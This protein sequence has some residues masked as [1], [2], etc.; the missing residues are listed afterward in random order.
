[1]IKNT[2]TNFS[3]RNLAAKLESEGEEV[4]EKVQ[5]AITRAKE[6]DDRGKWQKALHQ[7]WR[8][9]DRVARTNAQAKAYDDF[10]KAFDEKIDRELERRGI[11]LEQLKIPTRT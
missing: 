11:S 2:T 10:K 4:P 9:D 8:S 1:M 3:L 7:E 5:A 6:R